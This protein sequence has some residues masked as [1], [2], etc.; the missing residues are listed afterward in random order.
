[1]KNYTHS[2]ELKNLLFRIDR[3]L[4]CYE[5]FKNYGEENRI[6]IREWYNEGPWFF[7]PSEDNRVKGFLGTGKV[8]FICPRPSTRGKIPSQADLHFYE[9]MKKYGFEDA[10][11]TDL[12]KCRGMAGEISKKVIDNCFPFLQEEII[13]LKPKLMIAVGDQVHRALTKK[14]IR[15]E[16]ITHYAFRYIPRKKLKKKLEEDF[17]SV[18][19]NIESRCEALSGSSPAYS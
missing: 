14:S 10:H 9:L 16:K 12:V 6:R 7:P 4:E 2:E 17:R 19:K 15:S 18:R 8:I 11:I 3:C 1:M 5:K 13:I